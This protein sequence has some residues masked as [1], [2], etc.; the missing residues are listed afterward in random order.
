MTLKITLNAHEINLHIRFLLRIKFN[1]VLCNVVLVTITKQI[2]FQICVSECPNVNFVYNPFNDNGSQFTN[3]SV[4]CKDTYVST[5]VCHSTLYNYF[6]HMRSTI[7][8]YCLHYHTRST[9]YN[10]CLHMRSTSKVVNPKMV[11]FHEG[12]HS[13]QGWQFDAHLVWRQ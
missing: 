5:E 8:N 9:L 12:K 4:Y 13:L 6:L 2:L 3:H 10:Y 7:C 11:V 1:W